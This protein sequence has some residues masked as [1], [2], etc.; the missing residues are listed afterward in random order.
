M[1]GP[2][3]AWFAHMAGAQLCIP[4]STQV[5]LP[6]QRSALSKVVP[7]QDASPQIVPLAYFWQ[8]PAPSQDP[9]VLQLDAG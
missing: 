1:H 4:W 7:M 6:S 9:V 5:P 2:G 8:A 3:H